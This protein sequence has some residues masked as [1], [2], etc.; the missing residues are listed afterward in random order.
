MLS[1]RP[2]LVSPTLIEEL[3][4]LHDQVSPSPFAD[5]E[6]VMAG[7]LGPLWAAGFRDIDTDRPLGTASL[8]QVY[9]ATLADGTPVALKI[10]RPGVRPL[11][12]AD[13]ALLTKAARFLAR[14]SPRFNAVIDVSAMLGV[15]FDAMRPELDFTLEARNMHQAR[16]HTADFKHLTV[17]TPISATP[18]V[19]IQSLAPGCSIADARPHDFSLEERAGIGRDLLAFMYRSYFLTRTFH[20]DP[21]PGNI[22]V[23]PGQP[24]HLI[25]WGMVGRIDR[26]LST[27]ILLVLL[28][29]AQNDG[30]ATA[31]AWIEMGHATPWAEVT[32]FIEDMAALVPQIATATLEELNFGVTLT[33]ILEHSTQRGIKTSPMISVLGKSFAN[34]EG[35][36]RNLCPELSLIDIFEEEFRHIAFRLAT[37]ALS[38]KQ[39]ARTALDLILGSATAPQQTRSIIRDLS[40]R[41]LTVQVN[42]LPMNRALQNLPL[43]NHKVL[44]DS[45]AVLLALTWW[46]RHRHHQPPT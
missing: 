39:A 35:S 26:P 29:L 43:S 6:P 46:R 13:M 9:A 1:T 33:A 8:A 14:Q 28:S 7:D 15:V 25:D 3:Q 36:I 5:F 42:Q 10:Q 44:R 20:A 30:A 19:L 40:N 17:P 23:H 4:T 12:E 41:E 34:L 18:R 16:T 21:H 22:L 2:D 24:A 38:E 11:V 37:E 32:D 31:K 27:S 45:L